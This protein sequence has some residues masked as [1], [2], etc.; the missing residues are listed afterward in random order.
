MK[1]KMRL[2]FD[3]SKTHL[4]GRWRSPGSW[5]NYTYPD[6]GQFEEVARIAERGCMDML[7]FGDGTGVAST[8]GGSQDEAARWGVGW[9]RHD[10]SP[11]IVGMA[12]MTNHIGFGLTYSSTFM[13]PFYVARLLNSLDHVT[14][15]RIAFNVVASTRRSDAANYGFDELMEHDMRYERMEEF[16]KVCKALWD[17]VEPEAFKWDR[18]SGVVADPDKVH[19]IHHVG[20]FFRV[21]GPLN[22][23]PSPQRHPVLVQA[24]GS[25]RG[26]QASANFADIIFASANSHRAMAKH[27]GALDDALVAQGRDPSK[28]GMLFAVSVL[29]AETEREA[30]ARR[31][32]VLNLLPREAVASY[33]SDNCGYDF[34]RLPARFSPSELNAIIAATNASPVGFVHKLANEIGEGTEISQDEFFDHGRKMV[35]DYERTF[36]GTPAQMADVLEEAFEAG[37]NRGGFMFAS[38][39]TTPHDHIQIVDLL[40]PELRRRG[41]FRTEYEGKTL[42]ENL[43]L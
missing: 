41:R 2:A 3:L 43:A 38:A 31:E 32:A 39:P 28:V 24:G 19:A 10:M 6:P 15:G 8:Y 17:S 13:H 29:V 5:T 27:R 37:G 36:A 30:V 35:T 7:F 34:S 33:L 11:Y 16:I 25:L 9:P 14:K 20:E 22:T 21:R 1:K 26:I 23:V 18:E 12:R 4:E 42:K 40:I